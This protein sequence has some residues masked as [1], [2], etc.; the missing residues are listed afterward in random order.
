M[1]STETKTQNIVDIDDN[2]SIK[3]KKAIFVHAWTVDCVDSLK[4][5][6]SIESIDSI[7]K[8]NSSDS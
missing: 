7:E 6:E 5:T 2:N 3:I 1:D 8:I 4:P